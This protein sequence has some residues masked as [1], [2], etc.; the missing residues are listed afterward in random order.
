MCKSEDAVEI[1]TPLHLH[2]FDQVQQEREIK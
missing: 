1:N 2:C